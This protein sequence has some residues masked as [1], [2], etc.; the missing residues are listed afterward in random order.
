MVSHLLNHGVGLRIGKGFSTPLV[1][2]DES[3]FKTIHGS[4]QG[5]QR[6][7]LRT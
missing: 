7:E 4:M 6:V 5:I 1:I 2:S 3:S